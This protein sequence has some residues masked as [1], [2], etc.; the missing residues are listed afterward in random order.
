MVTNN[1]TI[2]SNTKPSFA[3]SRTQTKSS[4]L[5]LPTLPRNSQNSVPSS[6]PS[7]LYVPNTLSARTRTSFVPSRTPVAFTPSHG[8]LDEVSSFTPS[9]SFI[10]PSSV[11]R[12]HN[13]PFNTS[14]LGDHS[15]LD[16]FP[17]SSQSSQLASNSD[18][19]PKTFH[20]SGFASKLPVVSALSDEVSPS[21][22]PQIRAAVPPYNN[23]QTPLRST[24]HSNFTHS[25]TLKPSSPRPPSE[26][27][28]S[29]PTPSPQASHPIAD[30]S[31][32]SQL[33]SSLSSLPEFYNLPTPELEKIISEV[34]REDGFLELVS[35]SVVLLVPS[36]LE[37][38]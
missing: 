21:E 2:I 19:V 28:P 15:H 1:P 31:P 10:A 20:S 9:S 6:S 37:R 35:L 29:S 26:S 17:S 36:S 13:N 4:R 8:T 11:S 12:N 22:M 25:S 33:L 27:T 3:P 16:H 7:D 5:V 32:A 24:E 30:L 34:V 18:L 23:L 14:P 38:V